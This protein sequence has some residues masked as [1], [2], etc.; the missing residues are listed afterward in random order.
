LGAAIGAHVQWLAPAVGG[1]PISSY[2]LSVRSALVANAT[3]KTQVVSLASYDD[4][5]LATRNEGGPWTVVSSHVASDARKEAEGHA[6]KA[7]TFYDYYIPRLACGSDYVLAVRAYNS[8][9]GYGSSRKATFQTPSCS[10]TKEPSFP[11][12]LVSEMLP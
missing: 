7:S 8:F 10:P 11:P 12:T 3:A 2:E 1:A 9:H 6:S 5:A 4:D